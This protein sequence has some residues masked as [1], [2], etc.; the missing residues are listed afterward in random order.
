MRPGV[1]IDSGK[2]IIKQSQIKVIG[3]NQSMVLFW[4]QTGPG[5]GVAGKFGPYQFMADAFLAPNPLITKS[6]LP[7]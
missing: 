1:D 2:D 3:K 6:N 7:R 5:G 4:P